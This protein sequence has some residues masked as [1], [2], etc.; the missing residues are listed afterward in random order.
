MQQTAKTNFHDMAAKYKPP[1]KLAEEFERAVKDEQLR[2]L[3]N[4]FYAVGNDRDPFARSLVALAER[5]G[6]KYQVDELAAKYEFTGRQSMTVPKALEIKEE[7]E[8][9]DK[10]LKQME[11]AKKTAQIGVIDM[12]ELEQFADVDDLEGCANC[13][14]KST[15]TCAIR[16][17]SR[18]LLP[19]AGVPVDAEGLSAVS[20]ALLTTIFSQLQ[21]SRTGRHSEGVV[22]EGATKCSGPR[23]TNSAIPSRTWTFPAR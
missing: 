5:L 15:N 11:E 2:D 3:E 13:S 10:L 16:R 14:S 4:L 1:K 22:G 17:N 21:E 23:R 19:I 7:L 18:A 8:T 9:I 12:E 20:V 6:E